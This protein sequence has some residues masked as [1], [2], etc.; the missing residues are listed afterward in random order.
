L[1]VWA[2]DGSLF[3][4]KIFSKPKDYKPKYFMRDLNGNVSVEHGEQ[5]E[6]FVQMFHN[7]VELIG[8]EQKLAAE[9]AVI[10]ERAKLM[11][12]IVNFG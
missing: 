1:D 6:Q 5:S 3:T 12:D 11:D 9:R 8:D 2:E 7:F 10:L 4:E